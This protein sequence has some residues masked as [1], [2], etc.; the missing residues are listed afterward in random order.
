MSTTTSSAVIDAI[1]KNEI[2]HFYM[3]PF[4]WRILGKKKGFDV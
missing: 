4:S 2:P 1:I 3:S